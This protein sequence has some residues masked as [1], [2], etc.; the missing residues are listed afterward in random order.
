MRGAGSVQPSLTV[1]PRPAPRRASIHSR[2]T[3]IVGPLPPANRRRPSPLPAS[4]GPR[5]RVP[6]SS[7]ALASDFP[8]PLTR[9]HPLFP[10]PGAS[11]LTVGPGPR[12]RAPSPSRASPISFSLTLGGKLAI[13]GAPSDSGNRFGRDDREGTRRGLR[14]VTWAQSFPGAET[15]SGVR[16]AA[17]LLRTARGEIT[18]RP[19]TAPPGHTQTKEPA[20]LP[21][22]GPQNPPTP[23]SPIQ[24][25]R[26]DGGRHG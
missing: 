6:R 4:P 12:P 17:A 23:P 22:T 5:H 11:P 18:G 25:L 21:P 3:P 9:T 19:G 26:Q 16:A 10:G 7:W 20:R 15:E 8:L 13:Y 2:P 14:G 24:I 1:I